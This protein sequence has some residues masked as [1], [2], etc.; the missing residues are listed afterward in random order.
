MASSFVNESAESAI[1]QLIL[2]QPSRQDVITQLQTDDFYKPEHK[3][4]FATMQKMYMAKQEI[5]L[6]T[7]SQSMVEMYGGEEKNLTNAAISI[8]TDFSERWAINAHIATVKAC[9]MRRRAYLIVNAA[10]KELEDDSNDTAAVLEKVRQQLRDV[11]TT[12]HSWKSI[13]DVLMD[14]YTSLERKARGEE[15]SFPS[16]I[17]SLDKC[18]A[19]FHSGELTIIGARPAVG[20]SAL[21]AHIALAAA[22]R[23]YKVGIIS[24]EMAPVQYGT[25][26][27]A[28]GTEVDAK[29]LRTGD[30]DPDDWVEISKA[31]S[32]Y[33]EANI[34]FMFTA[35]FVEDL[36]MEVQK[37]V[38][39]K[40]LDILVIDYLQLLQTRQK[41]DKDYL[42][43]GYVSKMLKDMTTDFGISIIALAQVNRTSENTMPTLAELRGS[44]DLEQD[45]DNVI[46]MHRPKDASDMYV[47]P[48]DKAF[49]ESLKGTGM[50]YMVLKVAKQRQGEIGAI[51]TVF[52]PARMRFTAIQ[53][54]ERQ[55]QE[56][57][58]PPPQDDEDED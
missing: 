36:R 53:R 8:S 2:T 34:Q 14:T 49:F 56:P 15:S 40:N 12:K 55:A 25:R 39:S 16:G 28:N 18:T 50:Q 38:D 48:R 33:S 54:E 24:R 19:G 31:V 43:L 44:G 21:G 29:R 45:A 32:L 46:F 22:K 57:A 30:L 42:R 35:K 37:L 17:P 27:I 4:I 6:V 51:A 7:L 10:Q 23:G 52:D 47:F 26:I 3:K 58:L 41:F 1:L 9:A 13:T 5:D 20:K 11:V